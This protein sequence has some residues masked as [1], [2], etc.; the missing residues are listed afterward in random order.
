MKNGPAVTEDKDGNRF[1]GSFVDD[2]RDGDF[3]EK[4]RNGKILRK[5]YYERGR[6]FEE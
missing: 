6:R 2:E 3:V 1:E 4:D 5:G